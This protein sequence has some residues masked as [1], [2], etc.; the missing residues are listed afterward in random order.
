MTAPDSKWLP[1]VVGG[2]S[3]WKLAA[4]L[5]ESHLMD[6]ALVA[7]ETEGADSLPSL[8]RW[9]VSQVL[10]LA[11]ARRLYPTECAE[12][13]AAFSASLA[14]VAKSFADPQ[15]GYYRYRDA[16]TVPALTAGAESHYFYNQLERKVLVVNWGATPRAFGAKGEFVLA[17]AAW[18]S[19][20]ELSAPPGVG[21]P[22]TVETRGA[23]AAAPDLAPVA[24]ATKTGLPPEA[25]EPF[26][27]PWRWVVAVCG[28]LALAV[29]V[30]LLMRS[31]P[32]ASSTLT[33][34]GVD[35]VT[36][37]AAPGV[38]ATDAIDAQ[39]PGQ[40]DGAADGAATDGVAM[41][42]GT[43]AN[44][45]SNSNPDASADASLDARDARPGADASSANEDDDDA[46]PAVGTGGPPAPTGQPVRVQIGA[47]GGSKAGPKRVHI[48]QNALD[49][50]ISAGAAKMSRA[51]IRGT[52]YTVWLKSGASFDGVR[53]EWKDSGGNWHPH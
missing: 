37:A 44:S 3:L 46:E 21:A 20:F 47:G 34:S 41:D 13:E 9:D 32:G 18:N 51:V 24:D 38:D 53:V 45:D 14:R 17:S 23:D 1:N 22:D 16:F 28:L 29:V 30:A 8:V 43:D 39:V 12:A 49:W 40:T 4:N 33:D 42:G 19:L 27:V 5:N 50:R 11:E 52:A 26:A 15:S 25:E 36:D 35:A 48:N 6:G 10:P 31:C 2:V 7:P